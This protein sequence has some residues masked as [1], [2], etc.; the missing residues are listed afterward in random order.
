MDEIGGRESQSTWRAAALHNRGW[1]ATLRGDYDTAVP[2]LDEAVRLS[3]APCY[4][5]HNLGLIALQ[6]GQAKRALQYFTGALRCAMPL[7]W[8]PT[9]I[10]SVEGIAA[11]VGSHEIVS[12]AKLLG[13][14]KAERVRLGSANVREPFAESLVDRTIEPLR[15]A[16]EESFA[17]AYEQGT[18][19]SFEDAVELAL[20]LGTT[21]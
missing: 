11:A 4:S 10:E 13:A 21:S 15:A 12:A 17:D 16:A 6:Q 1:S 7:G 20:A 18:M 5:L 3:P 19:I 14:A 8:A 2:L 9:A